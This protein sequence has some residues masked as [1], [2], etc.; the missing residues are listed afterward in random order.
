MIQVRTGLTLLPPA[1][2]LF[3]E[4]WSRFGASRC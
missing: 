4:V 1:D 3:A 2:L